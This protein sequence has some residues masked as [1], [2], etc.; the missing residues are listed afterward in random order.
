MSHDT[1]LSHKKRLLTC[2]AERGEKKRNTLII[3]FFCLSVFF[4]IH[5]YVYLKSE[6]R[7]IGRIKKEK[8]GRWWTTTSGREEEGYHVSRNRMNERVQSHIPY[9]R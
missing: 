9:S 7:Q 2:G 6:G 8:E 4:Y 1:A 5:I 3:R